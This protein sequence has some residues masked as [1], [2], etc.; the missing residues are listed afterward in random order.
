VARNDVLHVV[1]REAG[2]WVAVY[3]E[4][5]D[6]IV[7]LPAEDE[8]QPDDDFWIAAGCYGFVATHLVDV[9]RFRREVYP[10][11]GD[12]REFGDMVYDP[13]EVLPQLGQRHVFVLHGSGTGVAA[14]EPATGEFHHC[15]IRGR[16]KQPYAFIRHVVPCGTVPTAWV[17]SGDGD[18]LWR[19][20]EAPVSA[21]GPP[22][23]PSRS[24]PTSS[25][26]FPPTAESF[27]G[28][29]FRPVE[30]LRPV[31]REDAENHSAPSFS[32]LWL[33][34]ELNRTHRA[35]DANQSTGSACRFS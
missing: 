28:A 12:S 14:I 8:V 5:V 29:T 34:P 26:A 21:P 16:R 35:G 6:G 19:V 2:E 10:I 20:G 1:E 33:R 18:F 31:R 22:A 9:D 13:T 11:P 30:S 23:S 3:L 27:F 7:V 32:F 17:R 25:S 24:I 4:H 15:W